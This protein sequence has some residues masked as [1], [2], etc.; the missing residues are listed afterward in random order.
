MFWET[1]ESLTVQGTAKIEGDN[2]FVWKRPVR[3]IDAFTGIP[4]VTVQGHYPAGTDL[5]SDGKVGNWELLLIAKFGLYGLWSGENGELLGW[6]KEATANSVPPQTQLLPRSA[7][8]VSGERRLLPE[9]FEV[10]F[11]EFEEACREKAK[12]GLSQ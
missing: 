3:L 10:T 6:T 12:R 1:Y 7:T 9:F 5:P 2:A 11:E 4:P 8:A